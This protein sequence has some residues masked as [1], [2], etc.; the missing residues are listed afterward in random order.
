MLRLINS[1]SRRSGNG[2]VYEVLTD[3]YRPY[4]K[5]ESLGYG[6]PKT[7]IDKI[8]EVHQPI[9]KYLMQ[10]KTTGIGLMNKD[11]KIA[12]EVIRICS[13]KGWPILCVHDS[14]ITMAKHSDELKQIMHKSYSTNIPGFTIKVKV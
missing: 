12:L 5:Y 9:A 1:D 6:S 11:S 2:N 13:N 14:F 8:L 3:G 10:D 7:I 4:K